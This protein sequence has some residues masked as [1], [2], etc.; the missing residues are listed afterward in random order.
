MYIHICTCIYG[1][2]EYVTLTGVLSATKTY[3]VFALLEVQQGNLFCVCLGQSHKKV[4]LGALEG[5]PI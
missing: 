5:M 4:T 1:Y 3:Y 2:I